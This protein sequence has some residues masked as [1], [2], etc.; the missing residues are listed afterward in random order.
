[1]FKTILRIIAY[2][3]IFI[4]LVFLTNAA[5]NFAT[6]A[7]TVW[8]REY[9]LSEGWLANDSPIHR[10]TP[11][12]GRL[13]WAG[14]FFLLIAFVLD[15]ET[16]ART[17]NRIGEFIGAAAKAAGKAVTSAIS[18]VASGFGW[19]LIPIVGVAAWY[20]LKKKE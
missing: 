10:W 15:P 4:A 14:V 6:G 20:F 1:M 3:L 18:G 5:W 19:L 11:S 12:P 9:F 7:D 2:I 8:L 16:T 17:M 13:A